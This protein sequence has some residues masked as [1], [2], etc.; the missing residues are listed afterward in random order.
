MQNYHFRFDIY[1]AVKVL[2]SKMF[3]LDSHW[4]NTIK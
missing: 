2:K 3:T 4:F 1:I